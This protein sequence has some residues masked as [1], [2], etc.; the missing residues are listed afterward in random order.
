MTNITPNIVV[1]QP[2]Q[3]FTLARS[4]KANA[5]GKIYIGKIDTDPVNQENQIPVYL[6]REDGTH[7]Q[8][9]QPIVIN[10]AG[11]PVYN[12]QIAK[13]VTVQGHSMAVYDRCGV[14]QF[15]FP[16]VLKYDPDQFEKR[17]SGNDG[18][19]FIGRVPDIDTL[20]T[21][22][23]KDG[24]AVILEAYRVGDG[25]GESVVYWDAT[26]T[27]NDN[28]G[29]VFAVSGVATG[30]WI[31]KYK[32]LEAKMFGLPKE[33]DCYDEMAAIEAIM[34]E[35]G[36]DCIFYDGIYAITGSRNMPWRGSDLNNFKSYKG[37]S[38]RCIGNVVFS[39]KSPD[40]AD[41]FQMN[42]V[43]DLNI[44]G[45]PVLKG[46]LTRGDSS[47]TN[48]VSI[49]NGGKNIFIE[50]E[51]DSLPFT[52]TSSGLDGGKAVTIQNGPSAVLPY[53]NI[54]INCR[55][56]HNCPY[57]FEMSIVGDSLINNPNSGIEVDIYAENCYR[58]VAIGSSENTKEIPTNG[59]N[60]G[61]KVR[62]ILKDCQQDIV[63]IRDWGLDIE[64]TVIQTKDPFMYN[65]H[66]SKREVL[67][68]AG[69]KY[70]RI[71]ISGIKLAVDSLY[72]IGGIHYSPSVSGRTG[73]AEWC[74][75]DLNVTTQV[76]TTTLTVMD[77]GGVTA[78]N[79]T[80][81]SSTLSAGDVI[82]FISN[83]NTVTIG[84]SV[85]AEDLS[86]YNS[87]SVF[88]NSNT[89]KFGVN[90]LGELTIVRTSSSA[91]S[92]NLS[93]FIQFTDPNNGQMFQIHTYIP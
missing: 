91:P 43:S 25:L 10:S 93:G 44:I 9:A 81:R 5:N 65:P 78:K 54:K 16:N 45:F 27:K 1:S 74:V 84:A 42:C 7:V 19:K 33:G 21:I 6:E 22:H 11:Y 36:V 61:V 26:S 15:Y 14:Q 23:G 13:F 35:E 92:S 73:Q 87:F 28:G 75:Y 59:L 46:T 82:A 80:L 3:L 17:L 68:S 4:F 64:A 50:V 37:A 2:S 67:E 60:H 90:K 89:K 24:D 70:S 34:F 29:T 8:V 58:G 20:R 30:R 51:A 18:F 77:S 53:Q 83:G 88:D 41:V 40:G 39:T 57:G 31:R 48:G 56:A 72:T 38:I 86:S 49:T 69:S 55:R 52:V 47:G 85:M 71:K 62:A 76:A 32:T 66:D 63:V 12:G 79:N